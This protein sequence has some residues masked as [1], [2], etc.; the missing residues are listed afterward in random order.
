MAKH[1]NLIS[2]LVCVT[3]SFTGC[4]SNQPP[5]APVQNGVPPGGEQGTLNPDG[6]FTP[7]PQ[8]AGARS[9]NPDH[10]E[11]ARRSESAS[12]AQGNSGEVRPSA[13]PAPPPVALTAPI[14][15]RVQISTT[16]TL[17][18]SQSQVGDT[19]NGVLATPMTVN[20]ATLFARGVPVTG[21]VIASKGRGRFKGAG[22]L[23]I[24]VNTIG[25]L[26]VQT[27]E[28]ER[29]ASGK[30]RR[31]GEFIGGGAGLGALIGGLAG[32]GKGALIGGLV[33]GGAGT[34]GA[35]YTGNKDVVIPAE[36]PVTFH[37]TAPLVV[38]H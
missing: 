37:L 9:S 11:E 38:T 24:E 25:G 21:T 36:S 10:R 6:S 34:A 17:S 20:G 26:R 7:A 30:G 1:S 19:F 31:T 27:D 29:S 8:Q 5:P 33:G 22:A 3:L 32:G 4:K 15:T 18:A 23:G 16:E 14:G 12:P 35:A 28:Y 2:A 13:V